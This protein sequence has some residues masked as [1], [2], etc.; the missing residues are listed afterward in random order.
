MC[1][2][3][4]HAV[5]GGNGAARRGDFDTKG[6]PRPGKDAEAHKA[7]CEVQKRSKKSGKGV[8]QGGADGFT[9][10]ELQDAICDESLAC[11]E[12]SPSGL[13]RLVNVYA[14]MVGELRSEDAL[15]LRTAAYEFYSCEEVPADQANPDVLIASTF[16]RWRRVARPRHG[17]VTVA[18]GGGLR[19]WHRFLLSW[20]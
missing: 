7:C 1:I 11:S 6:A 3:S 18:P 4:Y 17:G 10:G 15:V 12:F 2:P 16:W 19:E 5:R 9:L 14:G 20:N 13:Q 8:E